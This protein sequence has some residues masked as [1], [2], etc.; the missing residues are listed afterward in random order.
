MSAA[1][2]ANDWL[3]IESAPK[4]GTSILAWGPRAHGGKGGG[5]AIA[6][7]VRWPDGTA[8]WELG[9]S[10]T[11]IFASGSPLTHWQPL[12]NPPEPSK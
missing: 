12:P 8:F 6:E 10:S 3:P 5:C 11:K 9:H 1:P 2:D 7:F 4:D